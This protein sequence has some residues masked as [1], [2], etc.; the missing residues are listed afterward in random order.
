MKDVV[1]L[2]LEKINNDG[3]SRLTGMKIIEASP[4][5]AKA[6]M[7]LSNI[8]G[9]LFGSV[10]GGAI[11]SLAD[12]T[13]AAAM[14]SLGKPAV[15]IHMSIN[16]LAPPQMGEELIAEARAL[17]KSRRIG[18][19]EVELKNSKGELL[20]RCDQTVYFL[21]KTFDEMFGDKD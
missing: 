3:F 10:H 5:Y 7:S 14:N 4:G 13:A 8:H 19:S 1:D 15:A 20:A 18:V 12:Q 6:T 17:H 11:F 16:Y 2:V 9:N 21:D